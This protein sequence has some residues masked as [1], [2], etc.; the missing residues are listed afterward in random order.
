MPYHF[1]FKRKT[2]PALLVELFYSPLFGVEMILAGDSR[3]Y[4][5]L[6]RDS[7]PL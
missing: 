2:L 3:E 4:L 1:L 6:P 5:S 7:D